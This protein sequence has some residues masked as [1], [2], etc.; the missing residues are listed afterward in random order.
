MFVFS[1][2]DIPHILETLISVEPAR[3]SSYKPIPAYVIFLAARFAHNFSTPEL[4]DELLEATIVAI[5]SVTKVCKI[6][7]HAL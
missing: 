5:K 2:R 3:S 7:P 4:L 6:Y 1:S